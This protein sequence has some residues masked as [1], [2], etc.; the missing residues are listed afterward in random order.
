MPT[1]RASMFGLAPAKQKKVAKAPVVQVAEEQPLAARFGRD[2]DDG[3][4]TSMGFA[5]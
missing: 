5:Q 1:A 2:D 4:A 3:S